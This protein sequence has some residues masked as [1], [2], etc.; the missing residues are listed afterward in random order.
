MGN[1]IWGCWF[2]M[3]ILL[4]TKVEAANHGTYTA[5]NNAPADSIRPKMIQKITFGERPWFIKYRTTVF[6]ISRVIHYIMA[7]IAVVCIVFVLLLVVKFVL[8]LT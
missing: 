8:R 5:Q 3:F 1:R 2:L 4:T 6:K 7:I